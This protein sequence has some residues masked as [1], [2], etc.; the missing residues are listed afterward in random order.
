MANAQQIAHEDIF[1]CGISLD[2]N[3]T[4]PSMKILVD[5]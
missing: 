2:R 5:P 3:A 4:S 1:A